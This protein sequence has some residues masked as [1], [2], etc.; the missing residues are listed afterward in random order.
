ME[1]WPSMGQ[2]DRPE[3]FNESFNFLIGIMAA[4][5]NNP[6][7]AYAMEKTKRFFTDEQLRADT[8]DATKKWLEAKSQYD[9][10]PWKK[11]RTWQKRM[12]KKHAPLNRLATPP[13]P[14]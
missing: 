10:M 11:Q 1:K 4:L 14:S 5:P 7:V 13:K 9:G 3:H 6:A 8:S 2:S 12:V